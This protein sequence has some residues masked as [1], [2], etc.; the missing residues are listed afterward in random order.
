MLNN[1][2]E[3]VSSGHSR[4]DVHMDSETVDTHTRPT[5]VQVRQNPNVKNKWVQ[6]PISN[7]ETFLI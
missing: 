3:T 7:Q 4:T 2:K 5:Q 1:S 6:S